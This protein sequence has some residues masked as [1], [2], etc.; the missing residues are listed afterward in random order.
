MHAARRFGRI[1]LELTPCELGIL[2]A[3]L[4]LYLER[5]QRTNDAAWVAH[6]L[7]EVPTR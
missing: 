6:L 7:R 3:A 5:N 2:I 1:Y 4:R